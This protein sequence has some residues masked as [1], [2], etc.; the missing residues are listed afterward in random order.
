MALAI[1]LPTTYERRYL[2]FWY[3]GRA[4]LEMKPRTFAAAF[5]HPIRRIIWFY[6]LF[7]RRNFGAFFTAPVLGRDTL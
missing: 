1:F 4:I 7:H 6:K 5:Y 3:L 2:S